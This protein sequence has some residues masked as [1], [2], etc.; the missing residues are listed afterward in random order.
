MP[1]NWLNRA[2]MV[3]PSLEAGQADCAHFLYGIVCPKR[4]LP[5]AEALVLDMSSNRVATALQ[6]A[7]FAIG[8]IP[9]DTSLAKTSH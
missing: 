1:L 9:R 8:P 7:Y 4:N 6:D 2:S 3:T 5:G